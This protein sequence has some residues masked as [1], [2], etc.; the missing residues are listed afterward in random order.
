[1]VDE[2]K[3]R[4]GRQPNVGVLVYGRCGDYIHLPQGEGGEANTVTVSSEQYKTFRDHSDPFLLFLFH[5]KV[6]LSADATTRRRLCKVL[7]CVMVP[8]SAL[9]GA[10]LWFSDSSLRSAPITRGSLVFLMLPDLV[11]VFLH[12][13]TTLQHP[14]STRNPWAEAGALLQKGSECLRTKTTLGSIIALW[15]STFFY[16]GS[17]IF[18]FIGCYQLHA[19]ANSLRELR[20]LLHLHDHDSPKFQAIILH[21]AQGE[22]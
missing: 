19:A 20:N 10:F 15:D 12:S 6:L 9:L 21:L 8:L 7:P 18:I 22:P 1:M 17:F 14:G 2:K 5:K 4:R 11:Q 16:C 13:N 3:L